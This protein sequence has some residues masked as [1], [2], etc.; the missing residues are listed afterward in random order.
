MVLPQA[1]DPTDYAY[2]A[3]HA[4]VKGQYATIPLTHNRFQVY[5]SA[6]MAEEFSWA[7]VDQVYERLLQVHDLNLDTQTKLEEQGDALLLQANL[8]TPQGEITVPVNCGQEVYDVVEVTDPQAGLTAAR[9]RVREIHLT[10][11][12]QDRPACYQRMGLSRL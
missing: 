2:G 7:E 5:G 8:A 6:G 1:A 12:R 11:R 10:Y 9:Y 4:L 3:D